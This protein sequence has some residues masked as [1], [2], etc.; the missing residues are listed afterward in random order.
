MARL[1]V[2]YVSA[3]VFPFAKT[4]GLGDVGGA[5]PKY[6]HDLGV[7]VRVFL[8]FYDG[9]DPSV[10]SIQWVDWIRNVGIRFPWGELSFSLAV[11]KLPGSN[12][13]VYLVDC[14]A[15]YHR[16]GIYTADGDEGLRFAYFCRA[17]VESCQ[18]MGFGPDIF[19]CH[20]WHTALLPLYLQTIYS[21]DRLFHRSKTL[22]TIHNIGYQGIF[23]SGVISQVGL[24][25]WRERFYQEDLRVGIVNF[26]KTG[27]LYADALSAVSRTYAEEICTPEYGFGLDFLLRRRRSSLFGITNGVDYSLWSPE[28]DPYIPYSYSMEDLSGKERNKRALFEKVGLSYFPGVPVLGIVSRMVAQKGLELIMEILYP[29]LWSREVRFLVLGSGGWAYEEFFERARRDFP[30]RLY[31]YRG[32]HDALA[33]W[34]EAAADMFLMPSYYEPCGLNQIYSLRYGT[35]P[36]V[37]KTGGLAD[38]VQLWD[39]HTGEGTGFVFEHFLPDALE[40]AIGFALETFQNKTAWHRLMLNGMSLDYSWQ[41]QSQKYVALYR[42]IL[43]HL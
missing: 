36:I 32:Y 8:P 19:H 11:T 23:G 25:P 39:P 2:C 13:D 28:R 21:W 6:L 29:L 43:S 12:V 30:Q 14:P 33:H 16:G 24:S 10:Y 3:E 20:D 38:T 1:R 4:G 17:V 7:E 40:W 37:R 9:I 41:T 26:L 5:L 34:I 27:L 22:L 42:Y 18:R 15:L 31:Y 35:V